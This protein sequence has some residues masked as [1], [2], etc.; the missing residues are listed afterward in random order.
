VYK[1]NE[2]F[3]QNESRNNKQQSKQIQLK[4]VFTDLRSKKLDEKRPPFMQNCFL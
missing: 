4:N 1:E 3:H 2:K